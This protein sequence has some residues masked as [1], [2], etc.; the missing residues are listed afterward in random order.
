MMYCAVDEAFQPKVMNPDNNP[1]NNNNN[2]N[3]LNNLNNQYLNN[4]GDGKPYEY[5]KQQ[6]S[7][8]TAQGDLSGTNIRDLKNDGVSIIDSATM[9]DF[10][11]EDYSE[12]EYKNTR[13]HRYY[14]DKFIKSINDDMSDIMSIMSSHDNETYEHIRTCK[15]CRTQIKNKMKKL[16][17]DEEYTDFGQTNDELTIE[18]FT[19]SLTSCKPK[20]L[21]NFGSLG[22]ELKEI[23]IIIL[24][25][26]ILIFILDLLVKIGRKTIK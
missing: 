9:S 3:N 14:I 16:I 25:G 13:S 24:V 23:L 1:N 19:D 26:I 4:F 8:F 12:S 6:P 5:L 2:N 21:A 15:Y 20:N 11:M 7:F 22:Y 18:N 17:L 10:S